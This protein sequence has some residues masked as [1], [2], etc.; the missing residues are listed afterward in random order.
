MGRSFRVLEVVGAA[1]GQR[2]GTF[3]GMGVRVKGRA[4][5]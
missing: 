1:R 5:G 4:L 2:G 3:H